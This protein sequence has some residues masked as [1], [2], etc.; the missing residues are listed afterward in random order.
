MLVIWVET[1]GKYFRGHPEKA[2]EKMVGK[3]RE[4]PNRFLIFLLEEVE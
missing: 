1:L 2:E 4:N 3:I